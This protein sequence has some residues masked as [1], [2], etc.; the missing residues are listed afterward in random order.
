MVSTSA[1]MSERR[2]LLQT[3]VQS[4]VNYMKNAMNGKGVDRHLLGLKLCLKEGESGALFSDSAYARS[5]QFRISTSNMTSENF[6]AGFG[7]TETD[8]Y[9][10]C[11]GTRKES[12]WFSISSH[13]NCEST[14]SERMR[15]S[16]RGALDAMAH[17]FTDAKL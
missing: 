15:Q 4:H 10:F 9:G 7:P 2:E 3:A 12:L 5:Q 1:S 16:L 6:M 17:L 13:Y 8:G 14:C 11:Y